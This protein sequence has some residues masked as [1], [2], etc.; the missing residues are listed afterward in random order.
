MGFMGGAGDQRMDSLPHLFFCSHYLCAH[1]CVSVSG[2]AKKESLPLPC[3]LQHLL[4]MFTKCIGHIDVGE[5][6]RDHVC[7]YNYSVHFLHG[8]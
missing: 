1:G 5:E 4:Y 8:E 6:V 7:M 3:H 2:M